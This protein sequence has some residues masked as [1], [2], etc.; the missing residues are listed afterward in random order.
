[1]TTWC[2]NELCKVFR[3][4]DKC[5]K[6]WLPDVGKQNGPLP[7]T[8]TDGL[9]RKLSLFSECIFNK[10]II[11]YQSKNKSE[12]LEVVCIEYTE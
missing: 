8:K 6:V 7:N 12:S 1:M 9:P 5:K 10:M 3:A 11:L 2:S 4:K